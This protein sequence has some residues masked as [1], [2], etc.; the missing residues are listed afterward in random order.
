MNF[1]LPVGR[2]LFFLGIFLVAL[3]ALLPMRLGL[4]WLGLDDSGLAV[5]EARG[6]LW[7]GGLVEAQY[8][9]AAIGDVDAGLGF[10]PLLIGR[11]RLGVERDAPEGAAGGGLSGAFTVSGGNFGIDDLTASVPAADLFAP[12]PVSTLDLQDVT[13]HFENGLCVSAEGVVRAEL[14]G[15]LGGVSLPGTMTGNARCDQGALLLPMMGQSGM[16]QLNLRIEQGGAYS[17]QFVV[18]AVD[19]SMRER[20]TRAGFAPG[21]GGY[22]MTAQ[23]QF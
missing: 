12:L 7:N 8:G 20:L 22:Q 21:P 1:R 4:A 9:S 14:G 17:L 6:S 5:R 15:D 11:A 16:E 2:T 3:V 19:D 13:A 18:R 10:F 23:G